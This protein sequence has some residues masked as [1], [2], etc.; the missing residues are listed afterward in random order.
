MA[1]G[2]DGNDLGGDEPTEVLDPAEPEEWPVTDL[3]RVPPEPAEGPPPDAPLV[4]TETVDEPA[5]VRRR[6]PVAGA[7]VAAAI[8]L[9][10]LGIALGAWLLARDSDESSSSATTTAE[11]EATTTAPPTSTQP[12]AQSAV[13]VPEVVGLRLA[14]AR[15]LLKGAGLEIRVTR[16]SSPRPPGEVLEQKPAAG[17]SLERGELVTLTVARAQMPVVV[18][19]DVPDVVSLPVDDAAAAVRRSGLGVEIRLAPSDEQAGTVVEQEPPAGSEV[20]EGSQ[21]VL[22]VARKQ[23]PQ[24]S[25]VDVPDV[26]GS[27]ASEARQ[28]LRALGLRV[29]VTRV[30]DDA[31]EGTVVAQS[32]AATSSV[33]KG[34]TIRLR[35]SAGP[36]SV[37]V[38]DVLGL[39]EVA[40]RQELEAAGFTVR[41][42][43][44]P[45]DD[46]TNDGVVLEQSPVGGASSSEGAVVTLVVGRYD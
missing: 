1:K 39:D 15:A 21:V 45:T 3:Y 25:R 27:T 8:V 46:P 32:P 2:R 19:V 5:P 20:E 12:P 36:R 17:R 35:V 34:A 22:S 41:V 30:L 11:S 42:S 23:A 44:Q 9:A 24:A 31:P 26:V 37:T 10:T 6:L 16:R 7:G 43:E 38:P 13:E 40:A 28:T 4:V 14:N 33:R 18:R 29:S